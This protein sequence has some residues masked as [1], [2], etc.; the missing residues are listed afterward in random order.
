MGYHHWADFLYG[1]W[2]GRKGFIHGLLEASFRRAGCYNLRS[3]VGF[4]S[5]SVISPGNLKEW[6]LRIRVGSMAEDGYGKR[7]WNGVG[8]EDSPM[9]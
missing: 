5:L 9:L 2:E 4:V 7:L 1:T 8:K 6:G 3:F